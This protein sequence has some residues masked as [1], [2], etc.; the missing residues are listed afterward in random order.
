MNISYQIFVSYTNVSSHVRIFCITFEKFVSYI[1][2]TFACDVTHS[3]AT[4][5]LH[6][7]HGACIRDVTHSFR[8]RIQGVRRKRL[9]RDWKSSYQMLSRCVY[10]LSNTQTVCLSTCV[11]I[12]VNSEREKEQDVAN[13]RAL[14]QGLPGVF[15]CVH[16]RR[17][18]E[19]R[20]T[21]HCN[22]LQHTATHCNALQHTATHCNTLQHTATHCITYV[23]STRS[24]IQDTLQHT[25]THCNTLQHTATHCNTYVEST[26]SVIQDMLMNSWREKEMPRDWE[27]LLW[28]TEEV[29]LSLIQCRKSV[30]VCVHI[31]IYESG[32]L[33]GR[34]ALRMERLLSKAKKMCLSVCVYIRGFRARKGRVCL[35]IGRAHIKCWRGVFIFD[36]MPKR[37]VHLRTYAH[38]YL[39]RK[40][41]GCLAIGRA[42]SQCRIGVFICV[43]TYMWI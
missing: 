36:P 17:I 2:V 30:F 23:E 1:N 26:T 32:A 21:R 37:C 40:G 10:L 27:E 19:K 43:R 3:L 35:V 25:A 18:N 15:I 4:L 7:W 24:V 34:A 20:D 11:Y 9:P 12:H 33:Q 22:T 28:N 29:C 39:E 6:M 8:R 41:R 16:I 31:F 13:W 42:I 5:L 38:V 14:I